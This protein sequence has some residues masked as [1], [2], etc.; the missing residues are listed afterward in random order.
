MIPICKP[1][2]PKKKAL[3]D[4]PF[5]EYKAILSYVLDG[6]QNEIIKMYTSN[7]FSYDGDDKKTIEQKKKILEYAKRRATGEALQYILG[8]VNF[9]GYD[10]KTRKGVFIPRP[11]TES[12]ID[13][14]LHA[15]GSKYYNTKDYF[16]KKEHLKILDLCT[17][18]GVVALTI[19][20][21]FL[22]W[23]KMGSHKGSFSTASII[24]IDKSDAAIEL[25]N[26]NKDLYKRVNVKF[27][28]LAIPEELQKI[29]NNT[30]ENE[31]LS[32][33]ISEADAIIANPPYV[34]R[35]SFV[36]EEVLYNEPHDALF[37]G[38]P[39]ADDNGMTLAKSIIYHSQFSRAR[40]LFMEC[41]DQNAD[42]LSKFA[43]KY[44]DGVYIRKDYG[45]RKRYLQCYRGFRNLRNLNLKEFLAQLPR[46]LLQKMLYK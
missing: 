41:H 17:G 10:Y 22:R 6:D 30:L 28:K 26:E 25:A 34:P 36:T 31:K 14:F 38:N 12:M 43:K 4:I 8:E 32:K 5:H 15:I 29:K 40:M 11:E 1:P 44:F 18:S 20:N 16:W 23:G 33:I 21:E 3:E 13:H 2:R 24:G 7:I 46:Q 45:R 39:D 42:E 37:S 9:F 27:E 19:G 35:D